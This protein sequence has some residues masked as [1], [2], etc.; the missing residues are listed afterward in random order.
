MYQT[1]YYCV[2]CVLM[3]KEFMDHQSA[4]NVLLAKIEVLDVMYM[5]STM[6]TIAN[7]NMKSMKMKNL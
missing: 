4:A 5:C 1:S 7:L 2:H 3:F 6:V